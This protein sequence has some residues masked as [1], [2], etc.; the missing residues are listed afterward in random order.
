MCGSDG[1]ICRSFGPRCIAALHK[2][3]I[4]LYAFTGGCNAAL[5]DYLSGKLTELR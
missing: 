3:G 2:R 1:L 5:Q 4:A